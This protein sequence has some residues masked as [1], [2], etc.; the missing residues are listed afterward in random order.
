[1]IAIRAED[2]FDLIGGTIVDHDQFRVRV[3]LLENTFDRSPQEISLIV[4]RQD[5]TDESWTIACFKS[6]KPQS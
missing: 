5:N 6:F 2:P 4:K 1:M 3:G